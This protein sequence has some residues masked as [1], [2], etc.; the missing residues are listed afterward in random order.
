MKL[1]LSRKIA[2]IG[3]TIIL[4]LCFTLGFISLYM[5]SKSMEKQTYE[6]LHQLSQEG[7]KYI[8]QSIDNYLLKL[9]GIA[10]YESVKDMDIEAARTV[11]SNEIEELGYE[12]VSI[13]TP[14]RKAHYLLEGTVVDVS[15]RDSIEKTFTGENTVSDVIINSTN[16]E[17][18]VIYSVP[19]ENNGQIVGLI[20]GRASGDALNKIT[21]DMKFA[22]EGYAY[23]MDKN[24]TF[25]AHPNKDLVLSQ[26]SIFK[27]ESFKDFANAV[28][29]LGEK[30]DGPI[31]YKLNGK[32]NLA[33]LTPIPVNNWTLGVVWPES[34]AL[35]GLK[36]LQSVLFFTTLTLMILGVIASFYLGKYISAPIVALSGMIKKFANYDL[37]VDNTA[38]KSGSFLKRNDEIGEIA[39][40]LQTMQVNLVSIV[41]EIS[42]ASGQLASSAEELH[43]TTDQSSS[44]SEE[45]A[46]AIEDIAHGATEQARDTESGAS[47]IQELGDQINQTQQGIES[48]YNSSSEINTLK[49]Q[50]LH[51]IE[52]LV[53]KTQRSNETTKEIH[54]V[55][56]STNESAEKISSASQM[57]KSIAAQTNLLALN[58]AIE[59]ARAGESGKGF[60]VVAEE[61]RK[62]AEQSNNFT[63]E[64]STI[65]DELIGKTKD[66][67]NTMNEM[68]EIVQSQTESVHETSEKFEGISSAI[69]EMNGLMNEIRESGRTIEIKKDEIVS[70]IE[71]LS[72]ISEENAA[73]TEQAS[74][75][76]EE[77]SASILEITSASESLAELAEKMN[78][79][80]SKFKY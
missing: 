59:A 32:A 68:G 66:S 33:S 64:I 51:I 80:V 6:S 29:G 75:S 43:A 8:S 28:K 25:Y 42:D 5:S 20:S 41:R 17:P 36:S 62:L 46:R 34:D 38:A 21:D 70:V 73:G 4:L 2:L 71:N 22:K 56:M 72:A 60:A 15:G 54:N 7:S 58:A 65:I 61:I 77:Q 3:G 79:V 30:Q 55:I 23:L 53:D 74:A 78:S 16:G 18:I 49:D 40:S 26:K 52:D 9:E 1:N 35:A 12:D 11:L 24:G 13:V 44:A 47:G 45:V 63:G 57:I 14:D 37:Q 19:I 39:N 67:L 31:K 69:D 48:M 50:G 76:V 10:K 27:E